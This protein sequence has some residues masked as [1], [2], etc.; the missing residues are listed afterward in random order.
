MIKFRCS[1]E[2]IYNTVFKK[3]AFVSTFFLLDCVKMENLRCLEVMKNLIKTK[4]NHLLLP[5]SK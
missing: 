2:T 3:I 4:F 1:F 5:I